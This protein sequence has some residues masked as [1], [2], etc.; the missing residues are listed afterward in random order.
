MTKLTDTQIKQLND[1]YNTFSLLD[2]QLSDLLHH[3]SDTYSDI[4][5]QLMTLLFELN[6]TFNYDPNSP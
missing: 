2:T 5:S 1:I 3:N 4:S 6:D